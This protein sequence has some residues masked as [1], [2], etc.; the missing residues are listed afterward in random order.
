MMHPGDKEGAKPGDLYNCRC[1]MITVEKSGIVAED[2]K[3]R[4]GSE[5]IP[6]MTYKEWKKW[7]GAQTN[8]KQ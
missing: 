5:V 1:T 7:K 8:G 2:V 3:R 6:D 4:A